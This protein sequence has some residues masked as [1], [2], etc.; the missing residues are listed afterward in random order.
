M[1]GMRGPKRVCVSKR[2]LSLLALDTKVHFSREEIFLGVLGRVGPKRGQLSP[3]PPG[4]Q[5]MTGRDPVPRTPVAWA[6]TSGAAGRRA[7]A[8]RA[9]D[10]GGGHASGAWCIRL[11]GRL[12]A[13]AFP[14]RAPCRTVCWATMQYSAIRMV[15]LAIG[16]SRMPVHR[17]QNTGAVPRT[18]A[19][20]ISCRHSATTKPLKETCAAPST[21]GGNHTGQ[22]RDANGAH[23]GAWIVCLPPL[24]PSECRRPLIDIRVVLSV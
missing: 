5:Q 21:C 8:S 16:C 2:G 18:G 12:Q 10:R 13:A 1:G 11:L 3:T 22:Q 7:I 23:G 20:T 19:C 24:T 14:T 17:L 6:S 4:G 9:C 15:R